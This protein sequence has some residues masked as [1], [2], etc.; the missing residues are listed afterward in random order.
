[1]QESPDIVLCWSAIASK[2]HTL[3]KMTP[4]YFQHIL[5][6]SLKLNHSHKYS[7]RIVA[8]N[9]LTLWTIAQI[10]WPIF[11]DTYAAQW[12]D[13]LGYDITRWFGT[14]EYLIIGGTKS[15]LDQYV[16]NT[17]YKADTYTHIF[18]YILFAPQLNWLLSA[19]II[20]WTWAWGVEMPRQLIVC[21]TNWPSHNKK[22]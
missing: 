22:S 9:T 17:M 10:H 2:M 16:L 15:P 14:P 8:T 1:M 5:V 21:P 6:P 3:H 4:S 11:T 12:F 20:V 19:L 13:T 18:K 7:I